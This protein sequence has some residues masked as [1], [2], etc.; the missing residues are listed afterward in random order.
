MKPVKILLL[1]PFFYPEAI[2]TGKYNTA[3]AEALVRAGAEV[4]VIASHPFY[5]GWKPV[6]SDATLDLVFVTRGGSWVRYPSSMILRRLVFEI[7]YT[8]HVL[9][10]I[11]RRPTKVDIVVAVFPPSLFFCLAP[12]ILP[13]TARKVGIVH[14]FQGALGLTGGGVLKRQLQRVVRTIERK[15]FRS[16]QTLVALSN[17]MARRAVKEYGASR[18]RLVVAYPFVSLKPT[19]TPKANLVHLFPDTFHHVVYSGALGKKQNPFELLKFFQ[20][21]AL[22][23]PN[24][25]FHICSEGPIFDEICKINVAHP[26]DGLI[27]HGLVAEA[28]LEELYARSTVQVIPQAPRSEDACLPSK[29]PNILAAGCA[30]LGICESDSEL[31]NILRQCSA[32]LVSSWETEVLVVRLEKVLELV[33]V[34]SRD[35]RRALAGPLL[36]AQF[37]LDSLVDAVLDRSKKKVVEAATRAVRLESTTTAAAETS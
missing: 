36:A 26:V 7:W 13:S 29:L 31:A 5:P 3:L 32:G 14:D 21:A 20:T 19:S 18:E 34:Q 12:L 10:T 25:R 1:S 16:C 17:A 8:F 30:I 15:S 35:R 22:R 6:Y 33:K 11:W 37:T 2:S 24:V 27:C 4:R 28:D 23:F 9:W